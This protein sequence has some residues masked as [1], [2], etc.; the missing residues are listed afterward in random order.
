MNEATGRHPLPDALEFMH[1]VGSWGIDCDTQVV[2]YDQASGA[3]AARLWWLMRWIGHRTVAVLDGGYKGWV[4]T[5][6][7]VTSKKTQVVPR[8][9]DGKPEDGSWLSTEELERC[10]GAVT[11][12]D[13]REPERFRGESEP[14]DPVA[15]HIPSAIN[16]PYKDNLDPNG[17]FLSTERLRDRFVEGTGNEPAATVVHMCGLGVTA[18]HNVLAMEIA[19]LTGSRLYAGSWSEWI[20]NDTCG[21]AKGP[22]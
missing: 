6:N 18:C 1:R 4:A 15:G 10:L 22:N 8:Q 12:V 17:C 2:A 21:V 7:K 9:Y 14:I 3:F 19:G 13:A 5:G 16:L 20:R 11:L